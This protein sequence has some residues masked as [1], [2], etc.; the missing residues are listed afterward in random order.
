MTAAEARHLAEHAAARLAVDPRIRLVYLFGSA[1]Q[2]DRA[3]IGDLD[4]AVLAEPPLSLE[5]LLRRRAGL[6]AVAGAPIDL[7]SLS[8]AS[9]VLAREVADTGVCLYARTPD[10]EIE[11]VT[12]ARARYWDFQP[13]REEQWRLA[14]ERAAARRSGPAT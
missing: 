12:R 1:A 2:S 11:F 6:I 8:E 5:E 9:V 13:Y 4:L 3:I 14:G 10:L 7:V